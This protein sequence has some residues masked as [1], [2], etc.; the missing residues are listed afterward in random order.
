MQRITERKAIAATAVVLSLSFVAACGDDK[1]STPAGPTTPAAPTVSTLA[2][3]GLDA[4]RAGFVSTYTATATLSNGT[5]QTVTPTWTSSNPAVATVDGTGRLSGLTHGSI[6]L[7]A[8]YQGASASKNV[9][10]VNN[11]GGTWIGTYRLRTCDQSGVFRSTKWCEGL[12]G[13]GSV[14]PVT[15]SFSQSGN[16]RSQITG[17]LTLG[18]GI[19]GNVSG[20]VTSDGRLNIGG[21]FNVTSSGVT[22]VFAF[23]GWDTNLIS[24]GEMRGRWAQNQTAVGTAGNAYQEVEIVTMTQTS[25]G[26]SAPMPP[27]ISL[28]WDELFLAMRQPN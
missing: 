22:F 15:M 26:A 24:P 16:D 25:Q 8:S 10:I 7:A 27:S 12:G 5:S 20:S 4:I 9:N 28:T 19:T 21:S 18:T 1:S 6:S 17:S 13:V 11:Y 2:I 3:A 14:L 23:G